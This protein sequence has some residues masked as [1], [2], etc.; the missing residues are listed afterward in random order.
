MANTTPVRFSVNAALMDVMGIEVN[1]LGSKGEWQPDSDAVFNLRRTM[2]AQKPYCL[3]MNTDF[4]RFTPE[5]VEKYFQRSLFYGV[6]PSMF[7]VNA[8]DSPYWE[9][10]KWVN[11]DRDLFRKYIPI[12]KRLSAA[13]WEPITGARSANASV[14]V[15]RF[16]PRLFTVLNGSRQPRA[17]TLAIDLRASGLSASGRRVTNLLTGA[18]LPASPNGTTLTVP[19]SL[20]PEEALA[21]EVK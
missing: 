9:N 18:E 13:G 6:F 4:N 5:F 19:L 21:L 2:S 1:W 11:R 16:G 7:S 8:A 17:T 12:I 14:F 15:E 10:P 3:L 20:R